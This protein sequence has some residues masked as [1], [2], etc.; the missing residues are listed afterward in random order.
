[1]HTAY[2]PHQNKSNK[3]YTHTYIHTYIHPNGAGKCRADRH[4]AKQASQ[5]CMPPILVAGV[6]TQAHT[7]PNGDCHLI[8]TNERTNEPDG[9]EPQCSGAA[10]IN[11][12]L[13]CVSHFHMSTN[14]TTH[15]D[16]KPSRCVP[17]RTAPHSAVLHSTNTQT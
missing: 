11:Q 7:T 6:Q 10:A 12:R 16:G 8:G 2:A 13:V 17:H 4:T 15:I 3:R 9:V 5:S 1:M 14:K